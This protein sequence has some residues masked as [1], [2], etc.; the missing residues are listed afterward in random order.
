MRWRF[1]VRRGVGERGRKAIGFIRLRSGLRL[2]L[3]SGLRQGGG[4]FGA[5]FC[6]RVG[7]P[8]LPEF[9]RWNLEMGGSGSLREC[10]P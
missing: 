8:A 2:R 1:R 9:G 6:G 3:H 5:A 10:P 4:A 7:N